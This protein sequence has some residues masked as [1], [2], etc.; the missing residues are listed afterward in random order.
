MKERPS[1]YQDSRLKEL[2]FNTRFASEL[3][4][5]YN[6]L[7]DSLPTLKEMVS[8]AESMSLEA[9][10]QL[11]RVQSLPRGPQGERGPQGV[12]GIP[13]KDGKS[14]SVDEVVAKVLS[15]I[16]IPEDGMPGK[17][18]DE[19]K[20]IKAVLKE[21]KK[22]GFATKEDVEGFRSEIGSYRNQ[23]AMRQAGQHGG[24]TTV[25]AGSNI[26]LVPQAD[27]TV[28]INASGGGS[29]T[30]VTTQYTLTAVQA[31]DDVTI[32]LN[33]LTNYATFTDLIALYRNNIMQTEGA[34]YNFTVSGDTVTVF[35]AAADEIFNI[36]YAYS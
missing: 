19:E 22:M 18:A 25:S 15:V 33:Q 26:T 29:G 1:P 36:T 23:L 4:K 24:G 2:A 20:V 7:M 12:Q 3:L 5:A 27:G 30:N 16:R 32:D 21:L 11:A 31:G 34:S 13:G 10:N 28:Q 14:V 8:R 35:N 9:R 6:G 17:D